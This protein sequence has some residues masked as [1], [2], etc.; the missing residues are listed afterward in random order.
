MHTQRTFA[1]VLGALCLLLV[2]FFAMQF[3]VEGWDWNVTDFVI[4]AVLLSGAGFALAAATN[5]N[6]SLK[7]RVMAISIVGL[8]F[9]LYVHLA[10]GIVDSWPLAGS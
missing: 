9:I 3:G 7:R 6:F 1:F 2:P 4:M 5:S 8:L 10:V